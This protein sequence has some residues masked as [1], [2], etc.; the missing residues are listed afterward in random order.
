MQY[1]EFIETKGTPPLITEIGADLRSRLLFD[2][3]GV[4]A[5]Q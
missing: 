1:E 3:S 5:M 4:A 2:F